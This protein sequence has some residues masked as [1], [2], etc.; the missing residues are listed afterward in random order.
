MIARK[1]PPPGPVSLGITGSG[2]QARTQLEYLASVYALGEVAVFSPTVANRERYADHI[3]RA[4]GITVRPV[5]SIEEA[6][7]GNQIVASASGA[8]MA[9]PILSGEWLDHCRLWWHF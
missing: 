9:E 8:R 2:N 4:L 7:R 5:A 6:V 3:S 1:A